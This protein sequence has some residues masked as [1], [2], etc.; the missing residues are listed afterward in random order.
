MQFESLDIEVR[1]ARSDDAQAIGAVFDAAVQAG[2][3]YLG[4]LAKKPMFVSHDWD[5]LVADHAPPNVLLVA[6]DKTGRVL[7]F[8]AAHPEDGEMFLLFVHPASAGRGVGRMLLSAAHEG[9][10]AAGCKQAF[11][12]VHEQNR[13]ALAVYKAAGYR[14]DG[15]IRQSDFRG[16]AIRE[17]RLVKEL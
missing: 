14:P 2:W 15:S 17:V 11:L 13:R 12:F 9:L 16:T 4:E 3:T 8:T 6:A 10:R 7:G 1:H 5:Q